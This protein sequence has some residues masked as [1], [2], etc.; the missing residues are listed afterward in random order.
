[1]SIRRSVV[2][3]TAHLKPIGELARIAEAEGFHRVW[4]TDYPDRDAIVRCAIIG[5]A[6][7]TIDIGTGI[8]YSFTRHPVT[9]AASCVDIHEATG[10]RFSLGLGAATKGMRRRWFGNEDAKPVAR[11][12]DTVE[13]L[14]TLWTAPGAVSFHGEF[15]N[16][17]IDALGHIKRLRELPPLRVFGSGISPSMLREASAWCDGV[18]LHPLL[19]AQNATV[20]DE[21]PM[22]GAAPADSSRNEL[23]LSQWVIT[24][25]NNDRARARDLAQRALAFYLSTPSY[26]TQFSGTKW[27]S[28][29]REVIALFREVG[30]KWDSIIK[31]V[32]DQ[33]LDAYCIAGTPGEVRDRLGQLESTLTRRGV[34]ELVLQVAVTSQD[35]ETTV[36]SITAALVALSPNE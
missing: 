15:L 2:F 28:V 24:S 27:E 23:E 11:M 13:L 31:L 18:L 29:S 26:A 10:G 12:R 3:A 17:E 36:A 6:T 32:P 19:V 34:S 1:M 25:V 21:F 8:A 5:A 7:S 30:P 14:R 35:L 9:L 22:A 33:M 16:V 20:G 4:T